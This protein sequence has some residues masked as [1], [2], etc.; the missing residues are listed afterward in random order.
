MIR[1]T[2]GQLYE[3]V[4]SIPM[5]KLAQEFGISD[6]GLARICKKNG[7]PRPSLGYWAKVAYGHEVKQTPLPPLSPGGKELIEIAP[8]EKNEHYWAD[9][10]WPDL[11]QK[12]AEIKERSAE[13]NSAWTSKKQHAAVSN[14]RAI[15]HDYRVNYDGVIY[16]RSVCPLEMTVTRKALPRAFLLFNKVLLELESLGAIISAA[17]EETVRIEILGETLKLRIRERIRRR[18]VIEKRKR[19]PVLDSYRNFGGSSTYESKHYE[20]DPT[21]E[22]CIIVSCPE[23]WSLSDRRW[24]DTSVSKLEDRLTTVLAGIFKVVSRARQRRLEQEETKQR[25][26][27]GRQARRERLARWEE[28]QAKIEQEKARVEELYQQAVDWRDS[29]RIRTYIQGVEKEALKNKADCI[30]HEMNSWIDWAKK[31]A[32]RLD[33]FVESPHSIIDEEEPRPPG[34]D[35]WWQP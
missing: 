2:R 18:E 30:P 5:S 34:L 27:E 10:V 7:I 8:R 24:C 32:D 22:L 33:P 31:Q 23:C 3:K 13:I 1:I 19:M 29:Q 25:Q 6:V 4:W 15:Y 12:T 16:P 14:A 11:D 21:N 28:K 35:D 17:P 20:Y 9:G 26:A